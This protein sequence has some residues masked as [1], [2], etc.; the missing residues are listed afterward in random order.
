MSFFSAFPIRFLDE[1]RTIDGVVI[2]S[3]QELL[4][5]S[6][7]TEA[8]KRAVVD[9]RDGKVSDL[10][11]YRAGVPPLKIMRVL[12]KLLEELPDEPI[13][14]V[15]I[16]GFSGCSS[17]RGTMQAQPGGR[18]FE[19]DWDCAWRAEVNAVKSPW[20][21]IDQQKAAHDFGYQCFRLFREK[22]QTG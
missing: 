14:G 7:A 9:Y 18:E 16:D 10:I 1:P 20:G 22:A 19:F 3:L 8:F 6:A 2:H 12:L 17:F 4:D 15:R 5:R 11:Q 21:F 13:S